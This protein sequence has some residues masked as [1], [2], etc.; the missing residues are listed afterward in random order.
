MNLYLNHSTFYFKMSH[1]IQ[2]VTSHF[3]VIICEIYKIYVWKLF[4]STPYIKCFLV[5]KNV[6]F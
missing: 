3:F 4:Q 6:L 1:L 5:L 2:S